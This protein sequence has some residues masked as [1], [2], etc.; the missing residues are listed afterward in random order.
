MPV[1]SQAQAKKT[2]TKKKMKMMRLRKTL[3]NKRRIKCWIACGNRV[4]AAD[5]PRRIKEIIAETVGGCEGRVWVR[6]VM[7]MGM[8]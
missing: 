8:L 3:A 6:E 7:G 2:Q 5:A 1:S 4:E